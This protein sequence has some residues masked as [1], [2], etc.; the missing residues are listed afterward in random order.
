MGGDR[1]F[2]RDHRPRAGGNSTTGVFPIARMSMWAVDVRRSRFSLPASFVDGQNRFGRPTDPCS[3]RS[4]RRAGSDRFAL[5][6]RCL[7]ATSIRALDFQLATTFVL[8]VAASGDRLRLG[9]VSRA[10]S[11]CPGLSTVQSSPAGVTVRCSDYCSCTSASQVDSDKLYVRV[12]PY[13]SRAAPAGLTHL[14]AA[15][16]D[17][18]TR[19]FLRICLRSTIWSNSLD[20]M[21]SQSGS[22]ED[23]LL[24]PISVRKRGVRIPVAVL[25][26]PADRHVL[27][28][29]VLQNPGLCP[30]N[31][32]E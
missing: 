15:G 32:S 6:D 21:S 10:G 17:W 1:P 24:E 14:P 13:G 30:E 9:V 22:T 29:A 19:T 11:R 7:V 4:A 16:L 5:G 23:C 26:R 18:L 27:N 28:G 3:N 25:E 12:C 31:V 8:K 2:G 20:S